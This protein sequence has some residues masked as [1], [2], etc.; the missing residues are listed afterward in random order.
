[1]YT[2]PLS[3][4]VVLSLGIKDCLVFSVSDILKDKQI[5]F[6]ADFGVRQQNLF[7]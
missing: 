2:C 3:G 6:V 7:S 1:M 4:C 5:H